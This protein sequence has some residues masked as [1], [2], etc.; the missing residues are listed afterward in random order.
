MKPDIRICQWVEKA[1]G[2]PVSPRQALQLLEAAAA[3][4]GVSLRDAD[5]TI[6]EKLARGSVLRT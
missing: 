4:V 6:W 3:E 2:H 5:T 1:V